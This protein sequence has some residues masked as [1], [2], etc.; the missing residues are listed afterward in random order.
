MRADSIRPRPSGA[1]RLALVGVGLLVALVAFELVLQ[2]GAFLLWRFAPRE[3]VAAAR[4][5]ERVVL[6]VGD[7]NTYGV[8]ASD[9]E[10]A[11]PAVVPTNSHRD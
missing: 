4:G 2:A 7:S 8:G 1:K 6:C 3:E 5:D 10:Q 9:A 11:Y